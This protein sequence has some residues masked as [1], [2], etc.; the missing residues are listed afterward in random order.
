[1]GGQSFEEL[2]AA[3]SSDEFSAPIIEL[4]DKL[5]DDKPG[6][7]PSGL[8]GRYGVE[9]RTADLQTIVLSG[10][11]KR[12]SQEATTKKYVAT[13]DAEAARLA[14][15]AKA[16]VIKM[17]GSSEAEALEA[18]LKVIKDHGEVGITLAG[19]DAVQ[20]SSKGP[21]NTIIWANNPLG[22]LAGMLN[23]KSNGR[24]GHD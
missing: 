16:D 12:L 10:D 3:S 21:G 6:P 14:G 4:N 11:G 19:Y 8:K 24:E 23:P 2:I 15:Q 7:E 18:R 13:Q 20:E 5:P 22:G 1:V 17:V 9:I